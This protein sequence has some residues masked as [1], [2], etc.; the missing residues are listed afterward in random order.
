MNYDKLVLVLG[1]DFIIIHLTVTDIV[2]YGFG[3]LDRFQPLPTFL[4]L[5]IFL[6]GSYNFPSLDPSLCYCCDFLIEFVPDSGPEFW[7]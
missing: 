5:F 3:T 1:S 7:S 2:I 6:L 4:L